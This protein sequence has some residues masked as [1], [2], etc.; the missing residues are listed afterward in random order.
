[1]KRITAVVACL[2]VCSLSTQTAFAAQDSLP[3]RAPGK[4]QLTT[5]MDEG[6][7]AKEQVMTICIDEAMEKT[8]VQASL[9]EHQANCSKYDIKKQNEKTVVDAVCRY[10]NADVESQTEMEGDFEGSFTVKINSTTVRPSRDGQSRPI[11][12]TIHQS[13]KFLGKECGDLKPG[14]A[15]GSD[16]EKVF[17]Q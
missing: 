16:G 2:S 10:G 9:R 15:M 4:W 6:K 5:S 17:V 3:T 11:R 14:Q 7:G 1:M 13:G 12:R 8:T